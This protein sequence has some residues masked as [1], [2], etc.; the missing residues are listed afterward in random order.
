[1]SDQL[2]DD[3]GQAPVVARS[4]L[5][6]ALLDGGQAGWRGLVTDVQTGVRREWRRPGDVARFIDHQLGSADPPGARR[7]MMPAPTLTDVVTDMLLELSARLPADP[8]AVPSGN[9]TLEEVAERRAGLGDHIGTQRTEALGE[10]TLRGGRLAAHVRFQLWAASPDAVDAAMLTLHETLLDDSQDLYGAGFLK[11]TA[12]GTTLAEHVGSIPAWRKTSSYSV[13]YEYR[14][15]ADDDAASLIARIPVTTAVG[16]EEPPV[17]ET[18]T[19]TDEMVRWDEEGT[20]VLHI[21]GPG[22]VAR[23]SAL[24][25]VPGPPLGGTVTFRRLSGAAPPTVLPDL[26][27]FLAATT[28]ADPTHPDAEVALAPAD[29]LTALGPPVPGP[30]LGDWDTDGTLDA[31]TGADRR[32]APPIVL[33]SA[34]DRFEIRYTRPGPGLGLDQTAV[35]YLR[36]GQ[37]P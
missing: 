22:A 31:Y 12:A 17:T 30:T 6:R 3:D 37:L 11:L 18:E 28:G 14:Y 33:A 29:A 24:S 19:L 9:V 26:D 15:T 5:V 7:A 34:T 35:V 25:W 10:L 20:G 8:P 1:M 4:F 32:L 16:D 36:A 21:R 27:A 13:L 2:L 23:I